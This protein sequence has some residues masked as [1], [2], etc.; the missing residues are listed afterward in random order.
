[1]LEKEF[2]LNKFAKMF[3]RN[4]DTTSKFSLFKSSR[5]LKMFFF[6]KQDQVVWLGVHEKYAPNV[7]GKIQE[8]GW[9]IIFRD[10]VFKRPLKA[11]FFFF[12]GKFCFLF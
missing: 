9:T 2:G 7:V 11:F 5:F 1:M 12:F 6:K 4:N 8:T 10:A 3:S